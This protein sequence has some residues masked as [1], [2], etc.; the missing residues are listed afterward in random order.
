MIL[1]DIFRCLF[2]GKKKVSIMKIVKAFTLLVS[3]NNYYTHSIILASFLQFLHILDNCSKKDRT[4]L[5]WKRCVV[6][7]CGIF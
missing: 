6:F 5:W 3:A 4:F 1:K 7:K 2:R